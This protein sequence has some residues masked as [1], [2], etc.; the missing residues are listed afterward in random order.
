M[1]MG[2]DDYHFSLSACNGH[3]YC[4]MVWM[5]VSRKK[6]GIEDLSLIISVM[7]W[8]PCSCSRHYLG[9]VVRLGYLHV[10]DYVYIP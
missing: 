1:S 4:T 10:V 9:Q 8:T 3:T 2:Q 5:R 7:V 6:S